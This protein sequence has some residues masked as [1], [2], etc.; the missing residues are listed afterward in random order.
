VL[1]EIYSRHLGTL[2]IIRYHAWWP[3]ADDPYYQGNIEENT[4]RINYYAVNYVP[5]LWIDGDVDGEY[6]S[7]W[8]DSL[9]VEE[10]SVPSPLEINLSADYGESGD[11]G[12]LTTVITATDSIE[13]TDLKTR[14]SITESHLPGIRYFDEFNNVMRDMVPDAEGLALEI[15]EG[16]EVTEEVTYVLSNDWNFANLDFIVFV[17]SDSGHRVL[18]AAKF[19]PE[20]GALRGRITSSENG[21]PVPNAAVAVG[22]TS[23]G[24][25]TDSRGN[26]AFSFLPGNR[27]ITV[28]AA[29]FVTDTLDIT[30]VPDDTT[31]FDIQLT[32]EATGAITGNITDES[33]GAGVSARVTL[34]MN[35]DSLATVSTDSTTGTYI[36][37][38]INV[39]MPPWIVY[40]NVRAVCEVPYTAV[41][42]GDTILVEGGGP[43]QVD[44]EV[45]TADVFLVD[46]D[47]GGPYQQYFMDEILSTGRTYN[48]YDVYKYGVSVANYIKLFPNTS[49]V[50]WFSGNADSNIISESE[51][52]SL[53]RFLDRG[54]SLFL[55]GQNIVE[56]LDGSESDFLKDYL[57]VEYDGTAT[58][59]LL[60]NVY[61]NEVTGYLEFFRTRGDG[62]ADNQTS[63][64]FLVPTA[65]AEELIYYIISPDDL[66]N[67]GTAAVFIEGSNDSKVVLMGFGF[68]AINRYHGY[69]Y[70]ATR[71][72]TMLAILNWFDGIAGI[73]NG[74]GSG[75]NIHLPGTFS[76]S[77][78]F[79][80]PFNPSTTIVFDIPGSSGEKQHVEVTV[81]DIRGRCVKTLNDADLEPG[82]HKIH[83]DGRNDRGE[84]VSSGI[85]LYTLKAGGKVYTRKM[86]ILK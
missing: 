66:S 39:S 5:H 48:H 36:F 46:D 6:Q 12:T 9:I 70:Q 47:E 60:H 44:F 13:F 27:T 45:T 64:D 76:I 86:T 11:Y 69:E 79:P 10:E 57:H 37:N 71:E 83:W 8:W 74:G 35:G 52:D 56:D 63:R 85:Y 4:D 22:I 38:G 17:Q 78:N 41:T 3:S 25:S 84:S 29:G 28:G 61:G 7:S 34:Y 67:Q 80:N 58:F 16:E 43:T 23:Y 18:Q 26:Y 21:Y 81:Y 50:I 20:S 31:D 82:S 62:G 30:I 59:S 53:V 19:K 2:A 32:P 24:D 15:T 77:Q 14:F 55:T 1:D 54:G 68:E 42:L 72:E 65:P 33:T 75:D 49:S 51:Q 73:E 40:T